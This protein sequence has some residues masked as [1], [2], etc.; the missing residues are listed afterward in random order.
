MYFLFIKMKTFNVEN[1]F[2]NLGE[3][4]TR[5]NIAFRNLGQEQKIMSEI[6]NALGKLVEN[7]D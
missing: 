4:R 5:R 3:K 2:G 6:R 7:L 1:T